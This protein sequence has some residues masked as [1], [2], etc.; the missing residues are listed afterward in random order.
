MTPAF[1]GARLAARAKLGEQ[2]YLAMMAERF[3]VAGTAP[4]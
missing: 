4:Q 3:N 2:G 1:P